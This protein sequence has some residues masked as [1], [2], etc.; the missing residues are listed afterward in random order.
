MIRATYPVLAL[1]TGSVS[2]PHQISVSG[3]LATCR[4]F[5]PH[6]PAPVVFTWEAAAASSNLPIFEPH[7]PPYAAKSHSI[8]RDLSR[9]RS[10]DSIRS[11]PARPSRCT[12]PSFR[13]STS[14]RIRFIIVEVRNPSPDQP[15][16]VCWCEGLSRQKP[17][18]LCE[19]Q[20]FGGTISA[21]M[22]FA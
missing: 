15:R 21:A 3:R 5:S 6:R 4:G 10:M 18:R 20:C 19:R 9:L 13:R 8:P 2:E 12:T 1:F 16:R 22:W 14:D 17:G 7:S 11:A